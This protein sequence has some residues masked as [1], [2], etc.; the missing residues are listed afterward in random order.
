MSEDN[1]KSEQKPDK[2]APDYDI[3]KETKTLKE[4]MEE[5]EKELQ[6]KV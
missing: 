4:L 2:A 6:D 5:W 1:K 3:K